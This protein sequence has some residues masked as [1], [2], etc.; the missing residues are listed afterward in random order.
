MSAVYDA[1]YLGAAFNNNL[2]LVCCCFVSKAIIRSACY[3]RI[4]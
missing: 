2:V 3:Y 4:A 1:F